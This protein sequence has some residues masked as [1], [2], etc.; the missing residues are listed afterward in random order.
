MFTFSTPKDPN[1]KISIEA[2]IFLFSAIAGL[3]GSYFLYRNWMDQATLLP[4]LTEEAKAYLPSLKL[5]NVEMSAEESFLEQTVLK[6]EGDLANH[7]D[8]T[9]RTV[10]IYCIFRE[11]HGQEVSREL[12]RIF[13]RRSNSLD[14]DENYNFKLTFDEVPKVW[15]QALPELYIAQI[16]FME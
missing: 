15:N 9:L 3:L 10:D 4:Q 7:G 8:R 13:G 6:I 1:Q 2:S 12:V 5:N 16:E 11:P 14:P